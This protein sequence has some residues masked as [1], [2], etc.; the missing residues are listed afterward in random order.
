MVVTCLLSCTVCDRSLFKHTVTP[1]RGVSPRVLCHVCFQDLAASKK[2]IK[3]LLEE[4]HVS[5][6][7]AVCFFPLC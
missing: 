5:I 2:A 3:E 4:I 1:C 6:K 7:N